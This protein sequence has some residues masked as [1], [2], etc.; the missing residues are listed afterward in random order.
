M[1]SRMQHLL[2]VTSTLLV[3]VVLLSGPASSVTAREAR[4]DPAGQVVQGT[5]GFPRLPVIAPGSDGGMALYLVEGDRAAQVTAFEELPVGHSSV[6]ASPSPD[7]KRIAILLPDSRNGGST[8]VV[9]GVDDGRRVTLDRGA[10]KLAPE[11]GAAYEGITSLAWLD[12]EHILYSKVTWPSNEERDASWEAGAPLPIQGG[13]WL[14]SVDGKERRLLA[15][16]RIYRVLGASP[17]EQTLYVTRFIPGWELDYEEGFALVDVASGEI[18]NLWPPEERGAERYFSF[19]PV[20]LPDGTQRW[21]FATAERGDTAPTQ[22]PIIWMAD[23]EGGQAE[24]IWTVDRGN[25]WSGGEKPATIYDIPRGFLWSPRSAREFIYLADG[26]VLGGVWRVDLDGGTAEP[27]PAMEAVKR[28]DL[29]LLAWTAE[30]IVIQNQD[31]LWLLDEGGE[32]QGEIRFREEVALASMLLQG[33]VV[34]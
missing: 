5:G 25:D 21:L 2:S 16:D 34:D 22:P 23:V 28:T 8:L 6:V 29:R 18:K 14:S 12:D 30:G 20:A 3:L 9:V 17:D 1:R 7:G 33:T 31:A 19:T 11:K 24:A 15:S 13:V 32:V 4:Q 26:A 27:L 10:G